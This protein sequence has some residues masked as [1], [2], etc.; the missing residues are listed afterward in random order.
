[1]NPLVSV[2]I[3]SKN[4]E[5]IIEECLKS[6]SNQTYPREDIEIIVVDNNSTDKTKEISKRY[7]NLIFDHGP[8]RSVQRNFG[9][10]KAKGKYLLFLDADFILQE[11]LVEECVNLMEKNDFVGLYIPLRW[12]GN[13]WII[14]ARGFEREFYDATI[15]DAARFVK[16]Q[17]FTKSGGFDETLY[18]GEDWDFDRR[19][20]AEGS[21]G[22]AKSVIFHKEDESIKLLDIVKKTVY[23]SKNLQKYIEKWGN[24]DFVIRKQLGLKYRALYIFCENGK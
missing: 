6:V 2:V 5:R 22:L 15:L 9:A 10:E 7:T 12:I 17:I 4:N 16:R 23:Y 24:N 8:E 13:N 20:R 3:A 14:K 18:A 1:M 19:L 21:I 11:P